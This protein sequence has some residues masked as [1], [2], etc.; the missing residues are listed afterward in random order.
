MSLNID[1]RTWIVAGG[2][3]SAL[4]VLYIYFLPNQ[5]TWANFGG[6]GGDFLAAILTTGVPHPSGY[7]VY[8]LVGRLF[9]LLPISTP[10]WRGALLSAVSVGSTAGLLCLWAASFAAANQRLAWLVG[11]TAGLLWGLSPLVWSQAV[12]VEVYGLQALFTMLWM[13][14]LVLLAGGERGWVMGVLA[15]LAGLSIG[16]H[17]TILLLVPPAV[18]AMIQAVRQ[19]FPKKALIMQ[20]VIASAGLLVYLYLPISARQFPQVNWGNPQSWQ[21]F[22]WTVTGQPYRGLLF[23]TPAHDLLGR[24]SAWSRMLIEQFGIPGLVLGVLGVVQTSL[25]R[26][27]QALLLWIFVS[28]SLFAVGYKTS[29]SML[30]LIPA[31]LAAAVWVGQGLALVWPWV[32]HSMPLGKA[33]ALGLVVFILIGMPSTVRKVDPRHYEASQYAEAYLRDAP[34]GAILLTSSDADSFPLWYSVY[35]LGQRQDVTIVV[36]PLTTFG[37]YRETS[38]ANLSRPGISTA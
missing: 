12:I 24:V 33:A 6:D 26:F 37:W 14:W 11:L 30:Y 29:D 13:W 8:V 34:P 28:Y 19:G 9:Q 10:Y 23:H 35:G 15:L 4:T 38:H 25:R 27:P 21:G 1:R 31:F 17:L 18:W 36:L 22:I 7:P 16:N 32:W 3:S 20:L 5:L 2:L